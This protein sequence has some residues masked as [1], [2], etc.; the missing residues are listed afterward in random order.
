M[1]DYIRQVIN[2]LFP[3]KDIKE[4]M[5]IDIAISDE[6]G[7]AID[8]WDMMYKDKSP[9]LDKNTK[10]L[11]LAAA[12]ASE[13]ARLTTLEM[14]SEITGSPRADYLNEQ[15]QK[16]IED[17]RR[18]TEYAAAKGGLIFKPYIDGES[19]AVDYVQADE[20]LPVKY[21]SS[22]NITAVIFTERLRKG[23][24]I[25]TRL[26]YHDLLE[27]GYYISNTAYVNENNDDTLGKQV[28]LDTVQEWADLEPEILLQNIKKP[29]FAYYKIPIAN[30]IDTRSHLG[31]SVYARA[32]NLIKEADRQYSRTIWEYEGSELAI[33]VD[34]SMLKDGEE[35]PEG[36]ER[37][38]RMLDAGE[39]G[40][41]KVYSPAIRDE[42]LFNGLNKILQRI[43][44]N[45]G[46]AYGTLSDVQMVDKTAEEIRSSKQRTY[47]MVVDM[48]KGLQ[49]ALEDLI[50]AMNT[51]ATIMGV[52]K[53]EYEVSF[54]FDDSLVVD[55]KTEQT[56][57]L[58]E[59]S[60]GLIKPEMYLMERYGVTEEQAREMLPNM[61]EPLDEEDYDDME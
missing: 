32:V 4:A 57:M 53:G 59:V 30:T 58:Q 36:K 41:Y 18:V 38:F 16:V 10:S 34:L 12:I 14:Q 29:L 49:H 61:N 33:D 52:A 15:Y 7:E 48:Q 42:N 37:M 25:Y 5:N 13:L 23:S 55:S 19:T 35:I 22:G 6:M 40:F 21:D 54:D 50:Y 26:E 51:W 60:A 11:N 27:K 9:W 56:I 46:L 31:V 1:I 20:F 28:S 45:C 2:K 3:K 39:D 47:S 43:E 44:F 24:K 17:I 8:L